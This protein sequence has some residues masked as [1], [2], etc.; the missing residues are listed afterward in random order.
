M[1]TRG[2]TTFGTP[3]H[4]TVCTSAASRDSRRH[5][6]AREERRSEPMTTG[7]RCLKR[8]SERCR[9]SHR[10]RA[11][12]C[13]DDDL[14]HLTRLPISS[15]PH[16]ERNWTRTRLRVSG[17]A[18]PIH[19]RGATPT[20]NRGVPHNLMTE[21]DEALRLHL[22]LWHR[23][24]NV[25]DDSRFSVRFETV[26]HVDVVVRQ[27]GDRAGSSVKGW[28]FIGPEISLGTRRSHGSAVHRANDNPVTVGAWRVRPLLAIAGH[29]PLVTENRSVFTCR[30]LAPGR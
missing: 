17:G 18:S 24:N 10:H 3:L 26:G 11:R 22:A 20:L 25:R 13:R 27:V 15:A 29:N 9:R 16:G 1:A 6:G 7:R 14:E 21:L 2:P 5:S 28:S 19:V 8:S 12:H 30:R 23:Q 4:L